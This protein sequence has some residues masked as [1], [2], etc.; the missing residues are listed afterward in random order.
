M[1]VTVTKGENQAPTATAVSSD[2]EL[3]EHENAGDRVYDYDIHTGKTTLAFDGAGWLTERPDLGPH[4]A[5]PNN[6]RNDG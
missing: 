6:G 5:R 3:A 2:A 1:L 4:R